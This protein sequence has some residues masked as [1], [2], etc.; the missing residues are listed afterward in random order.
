MVQY[1]NLLRK[2]CEVWNTQ[3]K[4]FK[5]AAF[6]NG[7]RHQ[8]MYFELKVVLCQQQSSRLMQKTPQTMI[9]T[10]QKR[11]HI[12]RVFSRHPKSFGKRSHH[13]WSETHLVLGRPL[14]VKYSIAIQFHLSS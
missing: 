4:K 11:D 1:V 9:C 8:D 3:G 12:G 6:D 13:F 5:E 7:V 10:A 2:I 14:S